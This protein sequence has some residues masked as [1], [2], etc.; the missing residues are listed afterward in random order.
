MWKDDERAL[1]IEK[2]SVASVRVDLVQLTLWAEWMERAGCPA[3][4][5]NQAVSSALGFAVDVLRA[6]GQVTGTVRL[7]DAKH[8]LDEHRLFQRRMLGRKKQKLGAY[9]SFEGMRE[10]GENPRTANKITKQVYDKSHANDERTVLPIQMY[11]KIGKDTDDKGV[12]IGKTEDSLAWREDALTNEDKEKMKEIWAEATEE[13]KFIVQKKVY[14]NNA[15]GEY[16]RFSDIIELFYHKFWPIP[17]KYMP[18][19]ITLEIEDSFEYKKFSADFYAKKKAFVR[20]MRAM[21][22]ELV[23]NKNRLKYS[24]PGENGERTVINVITKPYDVTEEDIEEAKRITEENIRIAAK[25][26]EKKK[27]IAQEAKKEAA[28]ELGIPDKEE[29]D[30]EKEQEK[31]QN[32]ILKEEKKQLERLGKLEA[33]KDV[34]MDK[35]SNIRQMLKGGE[36]AK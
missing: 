36:D 21:I 33:K 34:V 13:E 19:N 7:E 31:M 22:P 18:E 17:K 25:D 10:E 15:S 3:N 11:G 24:E 1:A 16:D 14:R 4:S 32:R 30:L 12:E 27:L 35:I 8:W 23:D 20:A 6:N 29:I 2:T 5:V 26:K 28:R 9:I